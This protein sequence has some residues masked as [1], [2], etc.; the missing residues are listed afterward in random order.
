MALA[1]RYISKAHPRIE[2][3]YFVLVETFLQVAV[4]GR[5]ILRPDTRA[6]QD[7][8]EYNSTISCS[9]NAGV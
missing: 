7:Y 6:A 9:L 1:R 8:L 2:T 5:S 3:N 4:L